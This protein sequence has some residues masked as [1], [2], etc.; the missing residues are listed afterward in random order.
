MFVLRG[1]LQ[2]CRQSYAENTTLPNYTYYLKNSVQFWAKNIFLRCNLKRI[3]LVEHLK[4]ASKAEIVRILRYFQ[5]FP[6]YWQFFMFFFQ[7]L[8]HGKKG[9]VIPTKSFVK[10]GIQKYFVTTTK[11]LVLSTKRLVASAKFLVEATNKFLCYPKFCC[12]N[13]TTFFRTLFLR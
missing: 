2:R 7:F 1:V 6:R 9:F 10:I 3:N 11:C 13:K 12:R 5:P 8:T 4:V